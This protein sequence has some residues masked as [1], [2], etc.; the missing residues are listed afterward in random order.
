MNLVADGLIL[1]LKSTK[2]EN[3]KNATECQ[4]EWPELIELTS[5]YLQNAFAANWKRF[6]IHCLNL[7]ANVLILRLKSTKIENP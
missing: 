1:R 2:I 7:V 4:K 3:P 5:Y 6:W